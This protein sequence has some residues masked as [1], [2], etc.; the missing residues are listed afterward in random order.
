MLDK[1]SNP[2]AKIMPRRARNRTVTFYWDCCLSYWLFTGI[3]QGWCSG[4]LN[5]QFLHYKQKYSYFCSKLVI[6]HTDEHCRRKR[7]RAIAAPRD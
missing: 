6:P 5:L 1:I 3:T 7:I 4:V 2:K